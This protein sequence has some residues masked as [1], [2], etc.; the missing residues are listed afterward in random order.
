MPISQTMVYIIY[1]DEFCK[2]FHIFQSVPT[3]DTAQGLATWAAANPV[4]AVFHL[5]PAGADAMT[6]FIT[7]EW[8]TMKE[9]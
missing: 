3:G 2:G 7:V 4:A 1:F 5:T 8:E 6:R 9:S